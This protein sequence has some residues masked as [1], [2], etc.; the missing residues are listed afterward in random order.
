MRVK[1]TSGFYLP[2]KTAPGAVVDL[3][4]DE[5]RTLCRA[6]LAEAVEEQEKTPAPAAPK[7]AKKEGKK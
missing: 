5:A 4:Q 3:P 1:I 2:T 7:K 6:G